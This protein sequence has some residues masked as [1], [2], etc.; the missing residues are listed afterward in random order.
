MGDTTFSTAA[1]AGIDE[2]WCRLDSQ[3]MPNAF[4]N[5]KY[6]SNIRDAL[7]GQYLRVHRNTGVKYK[8]NI[9]DLTGYPDTIW[10]NPKGTAKILSLGLV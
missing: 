3:S 6:I 1:E 10:Y 5:G 2:N 8:N 4:I 7:D 9:V